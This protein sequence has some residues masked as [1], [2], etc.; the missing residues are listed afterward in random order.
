MKRRASLFV[1][2]CASGLLLSGCSSAPDRRTLAQLPPAQVPRD[3]PVTAP[4]P[5]QVAWRY[6]RALEVAEDPGLRLTIRLRLADLAMARAEA[7]QA[8]GATGPLFGDAIARYASLIDD[9]RAGQLPALTQAADHLYYQLAKAYALDG[10]LE[11]ADATLA[12]LAHHYPD[13]RYY[14]EAQFRR[15]EGAFSRGDYAEAED[16]YQSVLAADAGFTRNALYMR[17]WSQFARGDYRP[18]LA[19]FAGVLD[20]LLD[21]RLD[22]TDTPAGVERQWQNLGEASAQ[23]ADDS[24]RAMALALVHLEGP[25]ALVQLQGE[26]GRRPYEHRIYQRLADTYLTQDRYLDAADTLVHF[27]QRNPDSDWA[28]AFSARQIE[29]YLDGDYPSLAWPARADF[30]RRYGVTSDYWI[31]RDPSPEVLESLRRFLADLA[32]N[33]HARAQ[34][35]TEQGEA[36]Q[37]RHAYTEAAGWYREFVLS[38]PDD[39]QTG[40]MHFLLAES[41]NEAGDIDGALDAYRHVA[42]VRQDPDYGREAGYAAALLSRQRPDTLT[43]SGDTLPID[44]AILFI[45]QYPQDPRAAA[46]AGHTSRG[47]LAAGEL[48]R[49]ADLARQLLA[50]EPPAPGDEIYSAWLVLGHSRFDLGDYAAAEDAYWQALEL[51]PQYGAEEGG[52]SQQ[53]LRERIAASLYQRSR[54]ALDAGDLRTAVALLQAIPQRVPQTAIAAQAR[55]DAAHYLLELEDWPAAEQALLEFRRLHPDHALQAE[56]PARLARVHQQQEN[57]SAAAGELRLMS[58]SGDDP[59]L[60][61]ES[62]YLA[63]ELSQRAGDR[64]GAIDA[65]RDYAHRHPEPASRR[66]EAEYHLSELYRET[67]NTEARIYWLRRLVSGHSPG[68]NRATWLAAFA[69]SELADDSYQEFASMPLRLP[70]SEGLARKRR[71]LERALAEQEAVLN[72][73]VADFATRATH[74]IGAIYHQLSRDLMESDRPPGLDVLELE[75]YDILLEEQAYPFEEMAIDIYQTNTRRSWQGFYDAWVQRSFDALAELLPARYG[76]RENRVEVSR[77]IY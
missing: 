24:L 33:R 50:W 76:K 3:T 66:R 17:G 52:P 71:A 26:L 67:G 6:Q 43:D 18:A 74:R 57:W 62:L 47:L 21:L 38:F 12:E 56:I 40:E 14:A 32:R 64:A 28:P 44:T 68:D 20:L 1:A 31:T 73:G 27:V 22:G 37:A 2:L 10:R 42:F 65:Y 25:A 46:V 59:E 19:S 45:E 29:I 77:E 34:R 49:A 4:D 72:Y 54:Q 39:P 36:E 41:R 15:A 9:Y 16:H 63:A 8:E 5:E 23:V 75:Q 55:F 61:R 70:L 51:W 53:D 60:Q 48:E 58:A 69:A 30:V 11:E 35:L 13:S 7:E